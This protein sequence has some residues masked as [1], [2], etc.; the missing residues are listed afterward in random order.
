[1]PFS[2]LFRGVATLR[3]DKKALYHASR[4]ASVLHHEWIGGNQKQQQQQ[5]PTFNDDNDDTIVF[6][7]GLLGNGKNLKTL[8]KKVVATHNNN[9]EVAT[10]GLLMDL[11]GH[12][13]S[14]H[15]NFEGP[16][17][18]DSCV[19]DVHTTLKPIQ[20]EPSLVMG[21]SWGGRIAL[22]YVHSLLR[23]TG[24]EEIPSL[25][26]LDTVPGQAHDSVLQVLNAIERI[27]FTNKSRSDVAQDLVN[28]GLDTAIAQWLASTL[29]Q[30]KETKLLKWGFDVSVVR[31]IMP[32]FQNQDF[33]GLLQEILKEGGNV[34]LVKGGLNKAWEESPRIESQLLE[35]QDEFPW[36]FE[37]HT[38]EN[39]G[40]W[41]HVDDLP[42]LLNIVKEKT[43]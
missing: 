22:Q 11:R 23:T 17:T 37:Q 31:D 7:H 39:A 25:W 33:V 42:G 1:M 10:N 35:L 32:E 38:L 30:D 12:G 24:S 16:H 26:L 41:V 27:D 2:H 14:T 34:H 36:Q 18:F 20:T 6:L 21:H 40:H 29:Q 15:S 5:Q 28:Y 43:V 13:Q 19:E 4:I 9:R 3:H 8:A